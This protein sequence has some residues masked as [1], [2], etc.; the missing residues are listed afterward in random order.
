MQFILAGVF[1]SAVA[2]VAY[3]YGAYPVLLF[4][5]CRTNRNRPPKDLPRYLPTVTVVIPAFNEAAAIRRKIE[6]ALGYDYPPEFLEILV[7]EDGSTD[8]TPDVVREFVDKRV[9]LDQ[10]GTRQG[11]ILALNR[12]VQN[13]KGEIVLVTDAKASLPQNAVTLLINYFRDPAVGCVTARKKI[14][15]QK[16]SRASEGE[17]LYAKYESFI[18][19]CESELHSCVGAEGQG[20]AFRRSAFVPAPTDSPVY[21]DDFYVPLSILRTHG[22]RCLY[23]PEVPASVPAAAT[24]HGELMRKTRTQLNGMLMMPWCLPLIRPGGSPVW[25][26]IWSHKIFR[27]AV[28]LLLIMLLPTA[29][30]L[31]SNAIYTAAFDAQIIFYGMVLIG[32]L[33]HL[34]NLRSKVF[35]FP[36]YFALANVAV[37][38]ALTHLLRGKYGPAGV[39]WQKIERIV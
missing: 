2:I 28:P 24:L 4:L 17:G 14:T 23:A 35:Y 16:A 8:G 19:S 27:W 39:A 31:R 7:A 11:K 3:T 37:L 25:W 20:F 32:L 21:S 1:W 33:L 13:A 12:A 38:V 6:E 5:K 15:R 18:K 26:Q 30:V 29:F 10:A 36:L 9:I 34:A 22:L